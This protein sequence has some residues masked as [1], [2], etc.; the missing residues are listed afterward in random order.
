LETKPSYLWE[1]VRGHHLPIA[2]S[3]PSH[4]SLPLNTIEYRGETRHNMCLTISF[5]RFRKTL[6][7]FVITMRLKIR[8]RN[9]EQKQAGFHGGGASLLA[10]LGATLAMVG[11]LVASRG[12]PKAQSAHEGLKQRTVIRPADRPSSATPGA[13]NHRPSTP[14]IHP[15]LSNLGLFQLTSPSAIL[16]SSGQSHLAA[17]LCRAFSFRNELSND[18]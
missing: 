3:G 8:V 1:S 2:A 13:A 14:S 5:V 17:T 16:V 15:A 6:F 11:C 7:S 10:A 4:Y 12:N 9:D 18:G